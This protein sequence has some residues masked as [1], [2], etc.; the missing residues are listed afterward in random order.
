VGKEIGRGGGM[1][2]KIREGING[3]HSRVIVVKNG[4]YL[5]LK[6]GGKNLAGKK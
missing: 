3:S 1:S 6:R 5:E 2:C 4:V